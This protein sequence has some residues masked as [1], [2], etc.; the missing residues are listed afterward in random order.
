MGAMLNIY[1][2]LGIISYPDLGSW[3]QLRWSGLSCWFQF[4]HHSS[5]VNLHHHSCSWIHFFF[6]KHLFKK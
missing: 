1:E 4:H 2:S 3:I 5:S 6:L